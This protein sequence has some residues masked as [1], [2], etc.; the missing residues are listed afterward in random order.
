LLM[1][2]L[3]PRA[4]LRLVQ[5]VDH[6]FRVPARADAAVKRCRVD[7]GADFPAPLAACVRS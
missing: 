4:S 5:D 7:L 1:E 3:G 6:S 2:R